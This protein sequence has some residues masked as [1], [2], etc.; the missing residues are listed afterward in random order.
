MADGNKLNA[1]MQGVGQQ[2]LNDPP[3]PAQAQTIAPAK[4]ETA[5]D[6]GEDLTYLPQAGDPASVKWRGVEFKANVPRRITDLDHIEAAR[7]N[8]F[9]RVGKGD[10]KYEGRNPNDPPATPMQ[11]RAHVVAWIKTCETVEDVVKHWSD[12]RVLRQT[13]EVGSD[14]I[15]WL[16]S[17]VEPQLATFRRREGLSDAAVANVWIKYGVLDLPWRG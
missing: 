11:Y 10:P 6:E 2:K 13:C 5:P 8:R 4:P 9:F 1:P 3:R 7:T 12:D 14:D 17:L 16:G 15:Q